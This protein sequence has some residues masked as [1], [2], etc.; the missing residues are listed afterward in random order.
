MQETFLAVWRGAGGYRP[1]G[2]AG[3]WLWG[4]GRR[5]AALWLRRRDPAI[6]M[7]DV[8]IEA[9]AGVEA[10]SGLA[11]DLALAA[12]VRLDLADAVA[13]LGTGAE[14]EVWR[15]LHVEQ[16]PVAE[17]A[18]IMGVPEGTVKSRAHRARRLLRAALRPGRP[19]SSVQRGGSAPLQASPVHRGAQ[20]PEGGAK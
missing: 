12:A 19:P 9:N 20:V 5:Q 13:A 7:P 11:A 1:T 18:R 8:A 17:V 3:G 6:A 14:R 4:I 2:A 10:G 15:L 16:R